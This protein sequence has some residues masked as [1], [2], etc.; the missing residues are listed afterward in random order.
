[1]SAGITFLVVSTLVTVVFVVVESIAFVFD[2][3]EWLQAPSANTEQTVKIEK[4]FF[5]DKQGFVN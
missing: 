5:I 1:M 3:D 4:N 2:S